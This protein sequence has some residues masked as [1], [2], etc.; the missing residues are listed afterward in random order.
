MEFS[1]EPS[2]KI[3]ND[4]TGDYIEVCPDDDG[5]GCVEVRLWEKGIVERMI[6]A[7]KQAELVADSMIKI[8]SELKNRDG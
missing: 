8:A 4:H 7:P 2:F 3:Y 5:I 6:F 1:V